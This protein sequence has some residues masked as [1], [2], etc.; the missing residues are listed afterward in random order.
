[1][2]LYLSGF[3]HTQ[4]KSVNSGETTCVMVP[5]RRQLFLDRG[6]G[7]LMG[8]ALGQHQV[9]NWAK[10]AP[11]KAKQLSLKQANVSEPALWE[12][13]DFARVFMK[14]GQSIMYTGL[15]LHQRASKHVQVLPRVTAQMLR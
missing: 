13:D 3:L 11:D 5:D 4:Q 2:R 15:G 6:G 14:M 12:K 10:M 9:Q 8:T 7:D 1:M